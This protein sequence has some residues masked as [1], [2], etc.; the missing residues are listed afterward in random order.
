MTPPSSSTGYVVCVYPLTW[1]FP[2][3]K[4]SGKA[5]GPDFLQIRPTPTFFVYPDPV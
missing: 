5:P 2:Y 1:A 4:K 3:I